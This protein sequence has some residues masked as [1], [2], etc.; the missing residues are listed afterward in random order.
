MQTIACRYVVLAITLLAISLLAI[1]L[2]AV[3]SFA[4]EPGP[5]KPSALKSDAFESIDD[6]VNKAIAENKLPGAVVVIGY[7]GDLV[8]QRAYGHRQIEPTPIP[9]TVDTV[10]D[11]ASLT[12]PIATATSVMTLID[13]GR[14]DL[15]DTVSQH[16]PEFGNHGKEGITI[17]Q[18]LL[19]TS[20]LTPDNAISDYTESPESAIQNVMN[21]GL[22]YP[23]GSKFRYSDVGFIVL[24]EIVRRKT[25]MDLNAYSQQAI[26]APLEMKETSYKPATPLQQRAATTQQRNGHWM[27]GEVHDP[28]AYALGGVAGHAGLFST[29]ADL[30]VYATAMCNRGSLGDTT[31]VSK[32]TFDLMTAAYAVPGDAL[33]GLGWDK[34]SG[35]SS[36][37]GK[38][39]TATAFGHGGFTGTA[40]WIDPELKLFV[41]FLSNRVHP[42]GKGSVNALAG[43]IGTIAADAVKQ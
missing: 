7:Q 8:F 3:P 43:E 10:F 22:N 15:E 36:N 9:M 41:I 40:M 19:H 32:K 21:L 14:I 33:R 2:I 5:A 35:Y 28:R 16:L 18:L 24:G 1:S 11:L 20:G 37:R 39:M 4:S 31:I 30:A 6:L 23:T 38:T 42:N 17:K 25:G 13:Q 27:Q 26:F 12:K 34:Q 29:A